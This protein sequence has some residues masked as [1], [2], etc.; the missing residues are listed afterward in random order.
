MASTV[1]SIGRRLIRRDIN[2]LM[3]KIEVEPET[4]CWRW[5]AS[6]NCVGYPHMTLPGPVLTADPVVW[7]NHQAG[8]SCPSCFMPR[9]TPDHQA[10]PMSSSPGSTSPSAPPT[11][12]STTQKIPRA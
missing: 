3:A 8:G 6:Y 11:G 12:P 2:R 1:T 5:T 4:G 9:S 7:L 10:A